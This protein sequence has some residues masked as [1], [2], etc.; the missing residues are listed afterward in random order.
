VESMLKKEELIDV[1]LGNLKAELAITN[2]N[3]VDVHTG[4]IYQG[5]VAVYGKRIACIGDISH[6]IGSETKVL[7][8][9]GNYIIPG[10]IDAH[11]H[12]ESS[13]V[14]IREFSRVVLPHGTTSIVIDPHEIVNV[15]G[16]TGIRLFLE[17]RE[18]T[19]LRV[20]PLIPS[21]IPAPKYDTFG[22]SLSREDVESFLDTPN[23]LGAAEAS[24]A[25]IANKNMEVLTRLDLARARHKVLDGHLAGCSGKELNAAV[26]FGLGSDHESVYETEMIEKMRTGVHI[27]MREGS[28]AKNLLALLEPVKKGIETRNIS[29]CTDDINISD[30]VYQG[31]IDHIIRKIIGEGIDPVKAIQMATINTARYFRIDRKLGSIAPGKVADI[32][33][34][35][36]L[37]NFQAKKVIVDGKIVAS[38]GRLLVEIKPF[39]YPEYAKRTFRIS[40]VIQ[41]SD[42]MMKCENRK[43][44]KVHAI[45][46][47][48]GQILTKHVIEELDVK[49]GYVIPDVSKDILPICV[50]ERHKGTGAI[51]KAFAKGFGIKSGAIIST[52]AHDAHNIIVIGAD[53][54]DMAEAVNLVANSQGGFG[55]VKDKKVVGMME[56]PIAGLMSDENAY[57]AKQ[58]MDDV[59]RAAKSIG[60]TF[61]EPHMTLSFLAL[62]YIPELRLTDKGLYDVKAG[63]F[64]DP[65]LGE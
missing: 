44:V 40:R 49:D 60:I 31:H 52:V 22:G 43:S 63:R 64:I 9:K 57:V 33:I 46:A 8:A 27:M 65:I 3:V 54:E 41:A 42:L 30:L 47:I 2:G 21:L 61:E 14:G 51:A 25:D 16:A 59:I 62:I 53:Y 10:L 29:V 36:N 37:H 12:V 11:I 18:G 26:S 48:D 24:W 20:F 58:K 4:S 45:E 55:V 13:L 38:E 32:V 1:S 56:L 7:N 23:V 5:G 17:E 35:D 28:A 34:V 6:T 50:I 19:P 15:L 39:T